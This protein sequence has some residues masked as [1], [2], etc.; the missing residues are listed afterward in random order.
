MLCE[1]G[2]SRWGRAA[3]FG[4]ACIFTER[5]AYKQPGNPV[6]IIPGCHFPSRDRLFYFVCFFRRELVIFTVRSIC[7][8]SS[9]LFPCFNISSIS[10]TSSGEKRIPCLLAPVM[11]AS[12]TGARSLP[13]LPFVLS[14]AIRIS[15]SFAGSRFFIAGL[16]IQS[17]IDIISFP[18]SILRFCRSV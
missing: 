13:D 6:R 18:G 5:I 7:S 9:L 10:V 1:S 4:R 17:S 14:A 11:R 16:F 2:N 3:I 15:S 8:C 12:M